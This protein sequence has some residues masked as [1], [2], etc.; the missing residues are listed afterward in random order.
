[1]ILKAPEKVCCEDISLIENYKQAIESEEPYDLH[2]RLET[3]LNLSSQDLR[4]K[5]LYYLRPASELIFLPRS[6]HRSLHAS[7][8]SNPMYGNGDR[9]QG[10]KNPNFNKRW[11]N[12][13]GKLIAVPK[14]ECEKYLQDGWK[15]GILRKQADF[16]K[17][18]NPQ[19]GK[20]GI[21]SAQ[22]WKYLSKGEIPPCVLKSMKSKYEWTPL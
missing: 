17:E 12:K 2:H 19:F 6:V 20:K 4:D 13:D 16:S 18:K 10:D 9:I 3:E 5:G 14:S 7:G 21:E 22:Y 11:M 15:Y 1:M 8:E